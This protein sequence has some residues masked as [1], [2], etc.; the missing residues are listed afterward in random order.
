MLELIRLA[1]NASF[2]A[3]EAEIAE[4]YLSWATVALQQQQECRC[5]RDGKQEK[6]INESILKILK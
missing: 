3:E 1:G 2:H 6:G 4:N 5:G